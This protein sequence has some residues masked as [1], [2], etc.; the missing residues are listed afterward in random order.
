MPK[1]ERLDLWLWDESMQEYKSQRSIGWGEVDSIQRSENV[2]S[3]E[4]F[5]GQKYNIK[6]EQY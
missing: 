6:G 1:L 5:I 3:V 4:I 2:D